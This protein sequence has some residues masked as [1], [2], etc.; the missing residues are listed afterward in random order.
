MSFQSAPNNSKST[1]T[2]V[3]AFVVWVVTVD[4]LTVGWNKGVERGAT[5][6]TNRTRLNRDGADG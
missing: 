5:T 3:C 1:A 6:Y 2:I 4:L